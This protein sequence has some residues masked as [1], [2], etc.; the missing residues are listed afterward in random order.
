LVFC[1]RRLLVVSLPDIH[2]LGS[3]DEGAGDVVLG[4]GCHGKV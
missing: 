2:G 4:D 3:R 1:R